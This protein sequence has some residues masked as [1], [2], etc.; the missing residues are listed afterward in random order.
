MQQAIAVGAMSNKELDYF[1]LLKEK[2]ADTFQKSYATSSKR[3]EEWK[4]QDIVSFQEDLAAKVQ[5]RISEKWFY[6]HMKGVAQNAPR[7]DMLNLLSS[8]AG[9]QNWADFKS[10]VTPEEVIESSKA[11]HFGRLIAIIL[12]CLLPIGLVLLAWFWPA[13]NTYTFCFIDSDRGVGITEHPIEIIVLQEGQSPELRQCDSNGCFSIEATDRAM[14]FVVKS[15]YYKTDTITRHIN[16]VGREAVKLRT[17]DYALMIHIFSQS[18]IEDWQKRREQ[19]DAMIA[20]NAQF[21]QIDSK[22]NRP[23]EL[24]NKHEFIDKLTMPVNSLKNIEVIETIYQGSEIIKMR[25]KQKFEE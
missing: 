20:T 3:I 18:K 9:Y 6:T 13:D 15:A 21:Y 2:V 11:F 10:S 1:Q 12:L 22:K 8:Y 5:G 17:N 24:Y 14:R 4:G 16:G 7:I 19:L 25:F 23:I